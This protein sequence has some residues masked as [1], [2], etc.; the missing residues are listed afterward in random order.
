MSLSQI[1]SDPESGFNYPYY[2][3]VPD[4][5]GGERPILVVPT[6]TGRPSDEFDDHREAAER[7]VRGGFLDG[8][9][10]DWAFRYCIPSFPSR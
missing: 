2:L 5:Y 1:E 10:T 8:S 7:R 6:N 3:Y 4:E 9:P